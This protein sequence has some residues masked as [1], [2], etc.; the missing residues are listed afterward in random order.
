M[1]AM[2]RPLPVE[3]WRIEDLSSD[4]TLAIP[5]W[6]LKAVLAHTLE[7]GADGKGLFIT[8]LEGEMY[9]KVGD[10]LIQGAVGELYSVDAKVFD[11]TYD[12]LPS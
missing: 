3:V 6:V 8:T 12:I 11:Q 4:N 1:R 9:G 10:W 7:A 2:K 5:A